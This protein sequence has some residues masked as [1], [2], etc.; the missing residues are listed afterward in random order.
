MDER[1]KMTGVAHIFVN[2]GLAP[3][4]RYV[5]VDGQRLKGVRGVEIKHDVGMS[6][7]LVIVE[8]VGEVQFQSQN[9][10]IEIVRYGEKP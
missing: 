9:A 4:D 2:L 7:P 1:G 6:S 10:D 5:E 3:S 8:L